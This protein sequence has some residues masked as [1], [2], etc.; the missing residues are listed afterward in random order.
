MYS[1]DVLV[2]S[3]RAPGIYRCNKCDLSF[4]APHLLSKHKSK[5]CTGGTGDPDVLRLRH[6]LLSADQSPRH[7]SPDYDRVGTI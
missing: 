6:G 3:P 7:L 4:G 1:T 5:F 2:N